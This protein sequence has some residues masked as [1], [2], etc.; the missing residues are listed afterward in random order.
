MPRPKGS[1]NKEGHKAGGKRDGAG[2]PGHSDKYRHYFIPVWLGRWL[3]KDP[4]VIEKLKDE[5]VR[6]YLE[7]ITDEQT[8]RE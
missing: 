1:K 5:N 7:E 8:D 2:K 6:N 3:K 4:K